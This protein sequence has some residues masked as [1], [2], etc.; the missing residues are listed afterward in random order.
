MPSAGDGE[1]L[2]AKPMESKMATIIRHPNQ[3]ISILLRSPHVHPMVRKTNAPHNEQRGSAVASAKSSP[4]AAADVREVAPL[5]PSDVSLPNRASHQTESPFNLRRSSAQAGPELPRGTPGMPV[6]P[7]TSESPDS[8][9]PGLPK[10]S[11]LRNEADVSTERIEGEAELGRQAFTWLQNAKAAVT[12]GDKHYET[13]AE[14]MASAR[15]QGASQRQIAAFLGRSVGWVNGFLQWRERGY[16]GTPFDAQSR[17]SRHRGKRVVQAPEHSNATD[18]P[19]AGKEDVG[20]ERRSAHPA[21]VLP[22]P[23]RRIV[24]PRPKRSENLEVEM[25]QA[26]LHRILDL[27]PGERAD[28]TVEVEVNDGAWKRIRATQVSVKPNC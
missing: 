20:Q 8:I 16:A 24:A 15:D 14:A 28:I 1:A 6:Q 2:S 10:T 11:F 18:A 27:R 26:Q 19:A 5:I 3:P 7:N 22:E 9:H 12:A 25:D 13:A 4:E 17:Q 21:T 23:M